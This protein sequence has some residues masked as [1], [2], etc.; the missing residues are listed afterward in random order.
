MLLGVTYRLALCLRIV[1][2]S[3]TGTQKGLE[4]GEGTTVETM[5]NSKF[6]MNKLLCEPRDFE[7]YF[8]LMTKLICVRNEVH[9]LVRTYIGQLKKRHGSRNT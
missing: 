1:S 9:F 6:G 2:G 5:V 3:L 8:E 4:N 7:L